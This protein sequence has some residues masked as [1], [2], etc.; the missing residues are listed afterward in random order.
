MF[1]R[2]V[3]VTSKPGKSYEIADAIREEVLPILRQQAGFIDETVLVSDTEP[4]LVLA[5]SFW[6]T[7]EDAEKYHREQFARITQP[8]TPLTEGAPMVRT[9][10]VHT[11]TAHKIAAG[12]AA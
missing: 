3:E 11:S 9:F 10:N 12:I 2:I 5:M 6:K 7:K 1:T 8:I 4:N